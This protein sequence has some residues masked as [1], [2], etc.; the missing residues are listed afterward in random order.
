MK[1]TFLTIL[2]TLSIVGLMFVINTSDISAQPNPGGVEVI[3][4]QGWTISGGCA[5]GSVAVRSTQVNKNG[6]LHLLTI[7][8]DLS[9]TCYVPEK[10][11]ASYTFGTPYGPAE[12]HVTPS[13]VGKL[14]I[15]VKPE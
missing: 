10:G 1:K 15:V 7:F 14:Q 3:K 9:G 11:V 12:M 8:F 6:Q 4:N 5:S 13:G 2:T